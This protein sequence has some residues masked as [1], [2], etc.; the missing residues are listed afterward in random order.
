MSSNIAG[1]YGGEEFLIILENTQEQEAW[2][3]AERIRQAVEDSSVTMAEEIIKITI[4]IGIATSSNKIMMNNGQLIGL[5]DK[6]LY[7]AK[8]NGR[9]RTVLYNSTSTDKTNA[10]KAQ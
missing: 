6:A 4:S 1:R 2:Q 9:N 3:T 7:E 8:Q 5:A 10:A